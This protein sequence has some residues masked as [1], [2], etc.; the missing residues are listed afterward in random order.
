M[1]K[2]KVKGDGWSYDQIQEMIQRGLTPL[3]DRVLDLEAQVTS[4]MDLQVVEVENGGQ[5]KIERK[6]CLRD[7]LRNEQV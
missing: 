5:M 4:L 7:N 2:A 6:G 3:K 1:A